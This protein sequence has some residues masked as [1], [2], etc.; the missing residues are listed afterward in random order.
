MMA[1]DQ[2][3]FAYRISESQATLRQNATEKNSNRELPPVDI[4]TYLQL[5]IH[6]ENRELE[7]GKGS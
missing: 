4:G 3:A 1:T 5:Y 2:W 6:K 7:S